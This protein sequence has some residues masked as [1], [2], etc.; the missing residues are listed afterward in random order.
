MQRN[1]ASW[2]RSK[3]APATN[4]R[5]EFVG[6]FMTRLRN[7]FQ[8]HQRLTFESTKQ[9][10]HLREENAKLKEQL[11]AARQREGRVKDAQDVINE[12][13]ERYFQSGQDEAVKS[14]RIVEAEQFLA[15]QTLTQI[16]EAEGAEEPKY[17]EQMGYSNVLGR[18][19]Q[20][21]IAMALPSTQNKGVAFAMTDH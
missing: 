4:R 20:V 7:L 21:V 2:K 6:T 16:M 5:S 19:E 8:Q 18:L 1:Q 9:L 12:L 11:D 10:N 15:T 14:K 17:I 3:K 13:V